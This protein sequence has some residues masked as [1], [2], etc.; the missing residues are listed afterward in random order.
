MSSLP[1]CVN[2]FGLSPDKLAAGLL[3]IDTM[4]DRHFFT[5][6]GAKAGEYKSMFRWKQ[7]A[8][9]ENVLAFKAWIVFLMNLVSLVTL[10]VT[11]TNRHPTPTRSRDK[12]PYGL[13]WGVWTYFL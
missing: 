8:E 12:R 4:L 11:V 9:C 3:E 10:I 2:P 7:I 13:W 6:K 1:S 5:V